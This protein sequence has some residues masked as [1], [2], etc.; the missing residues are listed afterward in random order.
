M[1]D[2]P[3]PGNRQ[4]GNGEGEEAGMNP[5]T[6]AK[7]IEAHQWLSKF[8]SAPSILAQETAKRFRTALRSA[9][10]A[11]PR[12]RLPRGIKKKTAQG[13][14]KDLRKELEAL[15]KA[16]VFTRDC[17]SPEA[18]EGACITCRQ[19]RVLQWGHFIRQQDSKWLQYDP[20]N[21]GGQCAGCNGP[22]GRGR[23]LDYAKAI[24]ARDGAGT[25]DALQAEALRNKFWRPTK[26]A[27]KD[28]LD[29]LHVKWKP[30]FPKAFP[31]AGPVGEAG[32]NPAPG[33]PR[34]PERTP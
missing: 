14:K 25:A 31:A 28:K 29:D 19:W 4:E 13:E 21:T 24:D 27:L 11:K 16:I 8:P 3:G 1:G 5:K 32:G 10:P 15:C 2:I 26:A 9:V 7:W 6:A 12:I 30:L 18:R 17:G 22:A 20:R 33:N 23:P 34:T